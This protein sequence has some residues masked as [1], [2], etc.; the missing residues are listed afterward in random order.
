MFYYCER[1]ITGPLGEP[2]NSFTNI[3]FIVAAL[4][5]YRYHPKE[6]IFP[7]VIFLVGL[8]SFVFHTFPN[9]LTGLFDVLF[10]ISFL[11]LYSYRLYKN[12][13]NF[14]MYSACIISTLFIFSSYIFGLI[15]SKI[16]L[17]SS[18]YYLTIILH[19]FFLCY[20]FKKKSLDK[21]TLIY[22]YMPTIIF[23]ISLLF[24]IIDLLICPEFTLGT[25]FIWHM[26]NSIVLYFLV[27]FYN[28]LPN[29]ST[30]E[31]PS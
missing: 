30:P 5:L 28:L 25:H 3:F 29:R 18:A 11:F 23:I 19:L 17:K 2:L 31:V 6:K 22:L 4:L 27:K 10:I 14:D 1:L 7:V 21:K 9:N 24:R 16:F 15:F 8:G 13:L 26:L 20:L 12:K